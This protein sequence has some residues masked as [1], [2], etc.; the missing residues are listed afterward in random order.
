MINQYEKSH[1]IMLKA[2]S[3]RAATMAPNIIRKTEAQ[4]EREGLVW[5]MKYS[6]EYE[7]FSLDN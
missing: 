2:R 7:Y 3:S 6:P 4:T 1:P 5:R